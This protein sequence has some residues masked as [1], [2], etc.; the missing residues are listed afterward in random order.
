MLELTK[1]IL[2]S[3]SFDP[4]L[5][6]KELHKALKWISDADEVRKFHEWCIVE[7]GSI[8]PAIINQAFAHVPVRSF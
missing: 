4:K 5:F 3:V 7:F 2:K 6:K 1:K 8:Y